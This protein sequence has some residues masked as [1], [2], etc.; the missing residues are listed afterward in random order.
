MKKQLE[1]LLY[2]VGISYSYVGYP[3]FIAAV[4]MAK[5]DMSRLSNITK[6][7]YMPLAK[8]YGISVPAFERSLR[9]IRDVLIRNNGMALLE[10]LIGRPICHENIPYPKEIIEI[11]AY[12]L[13]Q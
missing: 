7:I 5:E 2:S 8:K 3:Y 6:N 1:S 13:R 9:T 11:F 10:E 4:N 12:Y